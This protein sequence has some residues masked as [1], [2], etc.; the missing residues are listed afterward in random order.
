MPVK[1]YHVLVRIPNILLSKQREIIYA[2]HKIEPSDKIKN[3]E[4]KKK[5][6]NGLYCWKHT[7]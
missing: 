2:V 1:Q 4:K 6:E 3:E 5:S 7:S